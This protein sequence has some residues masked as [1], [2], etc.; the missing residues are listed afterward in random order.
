MGVLNVT[1]DS[2]SDG[3]RYVEVEA[4]VAHGLALLDDGADWLD[5]GGESTR[6][7]SRSVSEAEELRRVVPVIR[8]L[9]A[10]RPD[11]IISI[12]T[13]KAGVAR[14]A[15]EAGARIVND[16]TALADPAMGPLCAEAGVTVVLMHMRGRPETMQEDVH[17]D[18]VVEEVR[19]RLADRIGAAEAMGIDRDRIVIDP[20]VGFG[21][22]PGDNPR[23][24][25][26]TRRIASLGCPVLIGASRKSF[27]GHLTGQDASGRLAGSVGAALAAAAAGASVLRIHDVAETRDALL[28]YLA[29]APP[30]QSS[31]PAPGGAR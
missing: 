7:G 25:G 4:A 31:P 26:A 2:F 30:A 19:A 10:R 9:V 6:P 22:A 11:A 5:V 21:K 8:A 17:Y 18:D 24:I 3:G 20:G 12:D 15:I 1:P 28:V 29:C 23:L 13:S 16:V 14:A 27:L